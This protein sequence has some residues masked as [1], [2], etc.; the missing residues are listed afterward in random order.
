MSPPIRLYMTMSL[1]GS[2]W[3]GGCGRGTS[4]S[5][6]TG[7]IA[8]LVNGLDRRL[9]LAEG[10]LTQ[11]DVEELAGARGDGGEQASGLRK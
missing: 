3:S 1:D 6:A 4:R 11:V 5:C 8:P 2:N 7:Y 10:G 9:P